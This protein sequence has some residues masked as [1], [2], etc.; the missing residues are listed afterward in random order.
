M[1][2]VAAEVT[3]IAE[4]LHYL[5]RGGIKSVGRLTIAFL[6]S[7]HTAEGDPTPAI[8]AQRS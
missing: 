7:R 2:I 5:G 6:S 4:N 3:E 8:L 1:S